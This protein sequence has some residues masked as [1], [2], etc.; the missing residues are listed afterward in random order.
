MKCDNINM[1]AQMNRQ[2]TDPEAMLGPS[3]P[4]TGGVLPQAPLVRLARDTIVSCRITSEATSQDYI[5]ECSV[6]LQH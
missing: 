3:M 2:V 4:H 1:S 6:C 5:R